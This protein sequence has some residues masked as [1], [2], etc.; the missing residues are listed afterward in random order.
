[1]TSFTLLAAVAL[2]LLVLAE[3]APAPWAQFDGQRR[4][5]AGRGGRGGVR[6]GGPGGRPGGRPAGATDN[7]FATSWLTSDWEDAGGAGAINGIDLSGNPWLNGQGGI[8]QGGIGQGGIGQG[9]NGQGGNAWQNGQGNGNRPGI[10]G[11]GG[12]PWQNGQNNGIRPAN[13]G[14]GGNSWQNGQNNGNRPGTSGQ[15]SNPW[16]NGQGNGQGNNGNLGGAGQ[17]QQARPTQTQRPNTNPSA[18]QGVRPP[19]TPRPDC[20]CQ[21]TGEYNPVCG[22]DGAT[23]SNQSALRCSRICARSSLAVKHLGAC[24]TPAPTK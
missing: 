7:R 14:Q 20:G 21:V 17:Q 9:G 4:G 24:T 5:A 13:N 10:N 23:Y 12:N 16:Q 19:S 2:G 22:T 6:P 3:A 1:M 11:Q 15:G 18:I 8:G